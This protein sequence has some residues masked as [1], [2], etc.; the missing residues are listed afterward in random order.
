MNRIAS[1]LFFAFVIL[2][3]SQL[4][5]ATVKL[6]AIAYDTRNASDFGPP[7]V[8]LVTDGDGNVL[9]PTVGQAYAILITLSVS[10]LG[11]LPGG[12]EE[13]GIASLQFEFDLHG[14]LEN[15][16]HPAGIWNNRISI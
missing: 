15:G 9:N 7:A 11:T 1:S 6:D 16:L 8:P 12:T 13:K 14:L 2:A 5:A 10:D 3:T 4:Q